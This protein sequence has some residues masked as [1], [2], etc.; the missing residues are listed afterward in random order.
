MMN[1]NPLQLIQM[2]RNGYNPQQL[3]LSI[4]QQQNPSQ[5]NPIL[6]NAE[7]LTKQGNVVALEQLAR[8]LAQ[9]KGLDFDTEFA[10]FRQSFY[11]N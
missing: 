1:V 4:L 3:V 2:I 8:N 6:N 5:S 10:K 11:K 9:Q 7:N